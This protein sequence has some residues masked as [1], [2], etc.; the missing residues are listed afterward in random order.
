MQEGCFMKS[1][2]TSLKDWRAY[3]KMAMIRFKQLRE[4]PFVKG[5]NK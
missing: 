2:R 4:I 1:V 3:E 5:E